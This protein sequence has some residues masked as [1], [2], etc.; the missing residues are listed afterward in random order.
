MQ[1]NLQ[2]GAK[3]LISGIVF[4]CHSVGILLFFSFLATEST[5]QP[6]TSSVRAVGCWP[7][8]DQVARWPV[9]LWSAPYFSVVAAPPLL[10]GAGPR[11]RIICPER[12]PSGSICQRQPPVDCWRV[13]CRSHLE[14][15]LPP[16]AF[17]L[18]RF[19]QAITQHPLIKGLSCVGGDDARLTRPLPIHMIRYRSADP[20]GSKR[21]RAIRTS[22]ADLSGLFA[23]LHVTLFD[24]RSI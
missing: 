9:S 19:R 12:L 5:P 24:L 3:R 20:Y 10:S 1:P 22:R 13:R 17:A 18:Q 23:R 15:V 21:S 6:R 2:P 7:S 16:G 14:L 8:T 4:S 11:F